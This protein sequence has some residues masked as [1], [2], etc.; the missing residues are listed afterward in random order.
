MSDPRLA[1]A[2]K[3]D[4]VTSSGLL[5]QALGRINRF[6]ATVNTS[7]NPEFMVSNFLRDM[8][9]AGILAGQYDI[10]GLGLKIIKL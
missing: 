9:T 1:R 7:L 3:S 4:Y 10:K 2:I 5:V 6:L 8:Q